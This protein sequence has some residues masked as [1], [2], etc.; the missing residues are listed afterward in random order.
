MLAGRYIFPLL[1]K[2]FV[3]HYSNKIYQKM[4]FYDH[5]PDRNEGEINIIHNPESNSNSKIEKGE[6]VDYEEI[7]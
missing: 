7:K 3:K 5:V 4:D 2:S 6:Y 1:L